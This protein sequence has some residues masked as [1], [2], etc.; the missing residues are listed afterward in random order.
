MITI[1]LRTLTICMVWPPETPG[2]AARQLAGR[3][4]WEFVIS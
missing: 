2:S 4:A 3:S 1:V